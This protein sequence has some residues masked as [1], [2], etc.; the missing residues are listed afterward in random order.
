[1]IDIRLESNVLEHHVLTI[2][3]GCAVTSD[4][5]MKVCPFRTRS[6]DQTNICEVYAHT[7]STSK[8]DFTIFRCHFLH[9]VSLTSPCRT[10]RRAHFVQCTLLWY[11]GSNAERK[12]SFRKHSRV[13][14]FEWF[15]CDT[16]VIFLCDFEW[17]NGYSRDKTKRKSDVIESLALE[18]HVRRNVHG[19]SSR[20]E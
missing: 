4:I 6:T 12:L 5:I 16:H 7:T 2:L 11:L 13:L 20:N 15:S 18:H 9:A 8:R 19:Y 10:S 14:M 17:C 3:I 1:M